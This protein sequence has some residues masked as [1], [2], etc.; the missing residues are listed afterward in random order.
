MSYS[1]LC[2]NVN[3]TK[4]KFR[5]PPSHLWSKGEYR[6]GSER[7]INHYHFTC[8]GIIKEQTWLYRAFDKFITLV[9]LPGALLQY[10]TKFKKTS[11]LT[12]KG[13]FLKSGQSET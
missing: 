7:K 2:T 8:P 9:C 1:T 6:G 5:P 13:Y 4:A 10:A 11:V 3:E 12:I